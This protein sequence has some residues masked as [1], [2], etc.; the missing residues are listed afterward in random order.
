M[1]E[2]SPSL[3]PIAFLIKFNLIQNFFNPQKEIKSLLISAVIKI[4]QQK[5]TVMVSTRDTVFVD[6]THSNLCKE[7]NRRLITAIKTKLSL[8]INVVDK[9][10]GTVP[11]M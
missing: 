10:L 1:S 3:P 5:S 6:L 11:Y 7:Y 2:K 8:K 9:K 4:K